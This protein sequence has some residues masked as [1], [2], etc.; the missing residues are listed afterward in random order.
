MEKRKDLLV[1]ALENG[2]VIDYIPTNKLFTV[3]SLLK[4]NTFDEPVLIGNNLSS[5][6]IG[7]KGMIKI[8]NRMLTDDEISRL[9]VVCPNIRLCIIRDYEVVEKK[10]VRL[11]ETLENVV[12]CGNPVCIS[13]NEPMRSYFHVI[14][15]EN[16]IMK[17]H[18]CNKEQKIE[19]AEFYKTF[20]IEL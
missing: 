10:E 15:K 2:T 17:C 19:T 4:L 12:R 20:S 16:G 6:K 14:D 1:A 11:P 9:A 18:Y 7:K 3:A 13:N 5:N 8:A